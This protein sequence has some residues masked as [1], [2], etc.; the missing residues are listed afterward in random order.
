MS[1]HVALLITIAFTTVC[2]VITVFVGPP[3]DRETLISFYRKVK[4]FGPGW[5]RI[6]EEAGVTVEEAALTHENMPMALL[7][8][9]SGCTAIWSALFTVGNFLY[10]RTGYALGLLA[11]FVVSG[12]AL[13]YVVNRL[14]AP[15]SAQPKVT[16]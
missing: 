8:W 9:V 7:G 16:R 3:T 13:L 15:A 5:K 10:G 6:R 12:L 1:T 2:W 4:P 11:V 14:W